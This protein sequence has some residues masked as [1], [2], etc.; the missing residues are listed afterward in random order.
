MNQATLTRTMGIRTTP[1]R[2]TLGR[3]EGEKRPIG[4][5]TRKTDPDGQPLVTGPLVDSVG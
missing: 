2:A 3:L 1:W 4:L 5:G